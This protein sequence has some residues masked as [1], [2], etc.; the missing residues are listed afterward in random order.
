MNYAPT[1]LLYYALTS[2]GFSE[3]PQP[4]EPPVTLVT[5]VPRRRKVRFDPQ[6]L[7]RIDR[8][9]AVCSE[10]EEQENPPPPYALNTS[11]ICVFFRRNAGIVVCRVDSADPACEIVKRNGKIV[12]RVR[13]NPP[14]MVKFCS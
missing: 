4:M 5:E 11:P 2:V 13:R 14:A 9:L 10:E 12:A 3:S 7:E 1:D 6:V 8:A